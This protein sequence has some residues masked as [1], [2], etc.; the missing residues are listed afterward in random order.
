M[1]E[2]QGSLFHPAYAAVTLGLIHGSQP[3]LLVLC[4]DSPRETI[5]GYPGYPIPSFGDCIEHYLGVARLTSPDVAFAGISVNSSSLDR[6]ERTGIPRPR[7]RRDRA[8]L[9]RPDR[10]RR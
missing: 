9:R 2:G 7:D 5:D 3:D 8:P 1:I 6:D 10:D 4:H